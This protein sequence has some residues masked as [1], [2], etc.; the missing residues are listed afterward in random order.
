MRMRRAA[1]SLVFTVLALV[2][3]AP[4]SAQEPVIADDVRVAGVAVGGLTEA[5]ALAA[6][7]ARFDRSVLVQLR[8]RAFYVSPETLG[9]RARVFMAVQAALAAPAD[10]AIPLEV[11]VNHWKLRVWANALAKR[12]YRP[13]RNS[14]AVLRNLRPWITQAKPGRRLLPYWSRRALTSALLKHDRGPVSL[15][16]RNVAPTRTRLNFGPVIVIRR[17]SKR[18]IFYKGMSASGMRTIRIFGVATG[19]AAYP[20]PLG[21]FWIATKQRNPWW[22]PPDAAW[23]A[24]ADPIPPGPGNPLGTRWMGLSVG[25]VGVHGT[26]DA[27]SIGYSASHGCIRMRISDAEWLFDRVSVGTTVFIVGA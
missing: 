9:S 8:R 7:Q 26:P 11:V 16:T 22:Y 24:G 27:A 18:L 25:G 2:V 19:M 13:P 5:E 20:T 6:V 14:R 15:P 23:A 3:V 1:V 21:H 4:A 17:D 12:F 10:T